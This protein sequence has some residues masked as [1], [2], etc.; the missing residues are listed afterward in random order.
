[1]LLLKHGLSLFCFFL[2]YFY[3]RA[4]GQ[5]VGLEL[6]ET[7]A[8]IEL[9]GSEPGHLQAD[10]KSGAL[11]TI[12]VQEGCADVDGLLANVLPGVEVEFRGILDCLSSDFF[13][14]F[15]VEG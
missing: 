2:L 1:L 8:L 11:V 10:F 7:A 4:L 15:I 6:A 12:L 5:G 14:I 13:I 9:E 3:S